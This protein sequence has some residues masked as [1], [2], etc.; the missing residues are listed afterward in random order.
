MPVYNTPNFCKL[1]PQAFHAT[2]T[3]VVLREMPGVH[4]SQQRFP[5][6]ADVRIGTIYGPGQFEQQ[7]YLTGTLV[8][9]GGSAAYRPIGSPVIRKFNR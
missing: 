9:G 1:V 2:P 8:A 4:N 6:I 7:G 3:T 5:N